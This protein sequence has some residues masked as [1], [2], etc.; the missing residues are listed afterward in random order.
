MIRN[1]HGTTKA[2][3]CNEMESARTLSTVKPVYIAI[4]CPHRQAKEKFRG[5]KIELLGHS[6]KRNVKISRRVTE[7]SITITLRCQAEL[8]IL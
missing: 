2:Q 8:T 6:E 3:A 4:Y 1:N 7:H 5:E